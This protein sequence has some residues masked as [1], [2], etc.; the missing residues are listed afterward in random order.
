MTP[1][2]SLA[3]VS[4]P[5]LTATDRPDVVSETPLT[6]DRGLLGFPDSKSFVLAV[7]SRDGLFWLQS[8]DNEALCFVLADPFAFFPGYAVDLPDID[9]AY[10]QAKNP[11]D[12][13]V[14]VT[15]TLSNRPDR[16]STANL[17]GPIAINVRN[18]KARQVVINQPGF[19][20][21]ELLYFG[22]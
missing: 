22:K 16:A 4:E 14:L 1:Q 12:V 8:T 18:R 17:Q 3:V 20:V 10:L 5:A 9:T 21:R 6:F 11:D 2:E 19:G 7:T 13:A 15:V